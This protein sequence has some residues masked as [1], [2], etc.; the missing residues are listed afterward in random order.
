MTSTDDMA[1]ISELKAAIDRMSILMADELL[2]LAK[3][4]KSKAEKSNTDTTEFDRQ[5]SVG[6][7]VLE[8]LIFKHLNSLIMLLPNLKI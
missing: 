8:D 5:I 6:K 7:M 1:T 2:R 3:I 4:E